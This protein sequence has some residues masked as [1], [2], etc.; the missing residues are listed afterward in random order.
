M[1]E[2]SIDASSTASISDPSTNHSRVLVIPGTV[3]LLAITDT[4]DSRARLTT[5]RSARPRNL[6]EVRRIVPGTRNGVTVG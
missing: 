4:V 2:I 6:A 1:I 5:A 3:E